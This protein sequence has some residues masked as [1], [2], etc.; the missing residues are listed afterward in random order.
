MTFGRSEGLALA[1]IRLLESGILSDHGKDDPFRVDASALK[2]LTKENLANL[3]Q[4]SD[5]NHLVGL[6]KRTD[7]LNRLGNILCAKNSIFTHN[8]TARPGNLYDHLIILKKNGTLRARD[9]LIALLHGMGGIWPDGEKI[10]NI[11]IGDVGYHHGIVRRDITSGILP[12][13]KLSQWMAYSL[14]EPLEEVGIRVTCLNDLTGLAEYRNGGLFM[15]AKVLTLKI[16]GEAK[17]IH[18]PKSS[19]VTEWRG[20]TIALLDKTAVAV[21]QQMGETEESLPLT[22]VLQGGTWSA[23]RRIAKTLRS[24]GRPPLILNSRGTIF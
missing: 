12:F 3:L 11:P 9:I 15:D 23:G 5:C 20:L 8:G 21:R 17:T 7:L 24:D 4:V 1:S 16:A 13:H 2:N 10:D 14:I 18:D 6:E 22:S 19:L